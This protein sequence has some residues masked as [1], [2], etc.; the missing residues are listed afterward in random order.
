[1][2]RPR[3]T[4][5]GRFKTSKYLRVVEVYDLKVGRGG[6]WCQLTTLLNA[7]EPVGESSHHNYQLLFLLNLRIIWI[8][9]V[10][11]PT[12]K[13]EKKPVNS[14]NKPKIWIEMAGEQII[15]NHCGD[16]LY[17]SSRIF[18]L[19]SE[20]REAPDATHSTCMR[21]FVPRTDMF[22]CVCQRQDC[23]SAYQDL[24]T[25]FNS[26]SMNKRQGEKKQTVSF[27]RVRSCIS[28]ANS[29][30]LEENMFYF[31][32]QQILGFHF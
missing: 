8:L 10:I 5:T 27:F 22:D 6:F 1:M 15:T 21:S 25:T 4:K 26:L 30:E 16:W 32:R 18:W 29:V 28:Q 19:G 23:L 11:P 9:I 3:Q 12:Q 17:L 13:K 7:L 31:S 20:H 2:T 24:K 14:E